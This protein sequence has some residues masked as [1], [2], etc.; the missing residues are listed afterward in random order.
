[1][2]TTGIWTVCNATTGAFTVTLKPAAGTGVTIDQGQQAE[3]IANGTNVVFGTSA[4]TSTP[5]MDGAASVGSG[6]SVALANHVHPTDTSRAPT[7]SPTFTG[8]VNLGSGTLTG[9]ALTSYFA[10]PPSIGNTAANTGAFTTLSASSTVSGAGFTSLLAPYAPLASPALTGTPTAPTAAVN[11]NSTQIATTAYVVGQ[12]GTSTPNMD[13]SAAT[14]TSLLYARQD[15]VHPTDTTR[16][17]LASPALTG[18]PTAPTAANGTNSTQLATTAFVLATNIN[19]LAA[20]TANVS[21]NNVGITNLAAPVNP[22][23]AATKTYVDAS[24]QGLQIKPTARLATAAALP[25]NT[26]NNGSSG[27]GATLTANANGALSVDGVVV[28]V[29]DVILVKNEATAANNGLYTVTAAG[30]ASAAYVLTRHIDMQTASEFAGAFVPVGNAGTTNANSLWLANPSGAITVGTTSI[31]FTQLNGATDLIA[32]TGV[33]ISG[34]TISISS[35][36]TGQTSI[37]TLGTI[38]TGTWNGSTVGVPYGGTGATTLTGYV[39]GNGTGAMTASTT[40]PNTAITGLGTMSTQAASAVAITGGTINGTSVGASTASTGAF[41]TLSASSTVSGAGFTA[42]AA[43]PPAIGSTAAN[44]GA[45]TTLSASS[46]V[47]GAGFTTLLAPYAPLA[48][49]ALTGNPTAPTQSAGD[50]STKLA[51]TAYVQTATQASASISTTGGSTTL[52]ATQYSVPILL[53][54]GT[55]TSNATLVVPNTGVWTVSNGTTGAFTLTVKTSAG[56]GLTIDQGQ[57]AEII[58]NGTNVVFATASG[59]VSPLMDGAASAGSGSSVALANH[60]HPTDTSRAPIASPTFTGTVTVPGAISSNSSGFNLNAA[61]G[62][63]ALSVSDPGVGKPGLQFLYN[64]TFNTWSIVGSAATNINFPQ[65]GGGAVTAPTAAVNTNTTQ[66]ATT[67]FVVG[68][69]GTS[70][71]NMDGTAATGTSLL[72]ARQDHV[73][74]TDTSRAP[75]A[76]PTFTGT[77]TIPTL[78]V[79]G[80]VSASNVLAGPNGSSGAPSWRQLSNSDISGLGTMATQNASSVAI[81][82]GT[83]D[84]IILDGGNF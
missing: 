54:T 56:T 53:V 28:A 15:H 68:Q 63:T 84:N 23:D 40:I 76:S 49:P 64:S 20:P 2:P 73:H 72:Y 7:A 13:G 71:P 47:S 75:I 18:T 10:S 19:Q 70:T 11:T 46:T 32:G 5:L 74:P 35:S 30:G 25:A 83:I 45:F 44:S 42:W 9:S 82:G 67:A 78:A 65:T 22:N 58:A 59:T 24:V 48:S 62:V 12:A 37:T 8:T 3:I 43:S 81:T 50:N 36:Y 21:W 41:T 27:V 6:S 69:A 66:I 80:S 31:P 29:G 52:T 14:G 1:M 60:V 16:A 79:T 34:N 38:A 17:P 33:S 61:S 51:T 77:V 55:L 4:G 26:Y 57:Q 39:Y